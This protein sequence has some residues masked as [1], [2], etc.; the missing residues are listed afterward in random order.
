MYNGIN[1]I[2]IIAPDRFK[3]A[4]KVFDTLF[5][6]EEQINGHVEPTLNAK[7]NGLDQQRIDLLKGKIV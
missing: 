4:H 3:Y 7:N 6:T 5:S 1:L 2:S